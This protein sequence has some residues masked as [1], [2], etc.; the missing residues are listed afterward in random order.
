MVKATVL[1]SQSE[2]IR[3]SLSEKNTELFQTKKRIQ[4][5]SEQSV[6]VERDVELENESEID[7]NN[8]H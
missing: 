5:Y 2:S 4:H 6:N 8:Y 3:K 7:V 1:K